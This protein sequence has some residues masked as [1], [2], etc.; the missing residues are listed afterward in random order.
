[1]RRPLPFPPGE[2]ERG[3]RCDQCGLDFHAEQHGDVY[4]AL[5]AFNSHACGST[6]AEPEGQLA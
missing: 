4:R 6:A 1:M 5:E 3:Y 2:P